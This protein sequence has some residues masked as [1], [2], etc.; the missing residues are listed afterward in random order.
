MM[1][2]NYGIQNKKRLV[3]RDEYLK[4]FGVIALLFFGVFLSTPPSAA[5]DELT[6]SAASWYTFENLRPGSF[7]YQSS[8]EIPSS[9]V[10]DNECYKF[11]PQQDASCLKPLDDSVVSG[12]PMMIYSPI[13][14]FVVGAGQHFLAMFSNSYA[15]Y[16]GRLASI[17][18]N[19]TL[20][21]FI[22]FKLQKHRV[23]NPYLLLVPL[24]PMAL[25]LGSTVNPSGL[26]V[27]SGLM[28]ATAFHFYWEKMQKSVFRLRRKEFFEIIS[29]SLMFLLSRQSAIIWFS[30]IIVFQMSYKG[31]FAN[32]KTLIPLVP[33]VFISTAYHLTHPHGAASPAGYIPVADDN[34]K[35]Y[36]D[37]FITSLENLP[38]HLRESYGVLGW[39]DTPA[40]VIV[41]MTFY[42]FYLYLIFIMHVV[43]KYDLSVLLLIIFSNT[44]L[45][46]LLELILWHDWP[47]WWQGRYSL[48]LLAM[49]FWSFYLK[50][51]LPPS[52]ALKNIS[53]IIL[54]LNL[55][56][57][58]ENLARYSFG[59]N[60]FFPARL[61]N[62]A[63]GDLRFILSILFFTLAVMI[64]Q[65]KTKKLVKE[66]TI[67]LDT[68][69][70]SK[71][72]WKAFVTD[73]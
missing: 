25:F 3:L 34:F 17:A 16:G 68:S 18:L 21:Y 65:K 46:S 53:F 49:S 59:L 56:V 37:G 33:S 8:G 52:S 32:L 6:H 22:L 36:F 50:A 20:L 28:F 42:F 73:K 30:I 2:K 13:Y 61:S 64:F 48:P 58:L 7:P 67:Q 5:P 23:K 66:S 4:T 35:Y 60:W 72:K 70:W 63:I 47:N 14:Y 26:E 51:K 57:L 11:K 40:P 15:V 9:I 55:G 24:T 43:V 12:Y 54:I 10:L 69:V 41:T 31:L 62:P 45:I 29:I 27:T 19:L 1:E 38:R 71:F 39:L 44:V